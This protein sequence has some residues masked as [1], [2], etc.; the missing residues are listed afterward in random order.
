MLS[1]LLDMKEVQT[2]RNQVI[3]TEGI[4]GWMNGWIRGLNV[5]PVER[6]GE[7]SDSVFFVQSGEFEISKLAMTQEEEEAKKCT[8]EITKADKFNKIY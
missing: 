1:I 3:F 7:A 2:L 6:T 8:T 4:Q 5:R